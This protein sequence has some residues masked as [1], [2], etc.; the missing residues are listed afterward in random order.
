MKYSIEMKKAVIKKVLLGEKPQ[1]EIARKAGISRSTLTY[2]L[3]PHRTGGN[4]TLNNKEKRPQDWTSEERIGALIKA[5]S[6]S[7]E[8]RVSWCRK[9]GLFGHHLE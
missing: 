8:E 7:D 5:G 4:I 2:R 6:M 1:Y 9:E 3:K